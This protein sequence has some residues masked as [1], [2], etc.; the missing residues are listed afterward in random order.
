MFFY[1]LAGVAAL[2]ALHKKPEAVGPMGE[3]QD[4]FPYGST[5][6]DGTGTG[7]DEIHDNQFASSPSRNI[8]FNQMFSIDEIDVENDRPEYPSVL[9]NVQKPREFFKSNISTEQQLPSLRKNKWVAQGGE[10]Q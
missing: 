6:Q 8:S 1:L 2:Y 10:N 3:P 5:L 7:A 4:P 9:G